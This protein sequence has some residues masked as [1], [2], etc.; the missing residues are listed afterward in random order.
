MN[1]GSGSGSLPTADAASAAALVRGSSNVFLPVGQPIATEPAP[2]SAGAAASGDALDRELM[3]R[4]SSSSFDGVSFADDD[5]DAA[6]APFA[7]EVA[8]T[9][10]SSRTTF[11]HSRSQ[12]FHSRSFALK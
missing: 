5:A 10:F 12:I 1:F 6:A 3:L 9:Y 11:P 4:T 2:S 8:S 7:F